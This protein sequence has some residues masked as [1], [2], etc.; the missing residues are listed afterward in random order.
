[1][2]LHE[3]FI[4]RTQ[5]IR[6]KNFESGPVD[7]TKKLKLSYYRR[8]FKNSVKS[9]KKAQSGN[10]LTLGIFIFEKVQMKLDVP[11]LIIS[12]LAETNRSSFDFR[13]SASG[14]N[15]EVTYK[16]LSIIQ[17]CLQF[18]FF[19]FGPVEVFLLIGT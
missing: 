1:M 3:N 12:V 8:S 10:I 4:S 11:I 15:V 5:L 2:V 16:I 18:Y 7:N 19:G 6:A 9:S 13:D 14:V 17:I